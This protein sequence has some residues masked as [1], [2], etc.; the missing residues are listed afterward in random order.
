M[1]PV[2]PPMR[3]FA[4]NPSA[5]SIGV[6]SRICPFH[7]VPSQFQYFTPVGIAMRNDMPA[8]NPLATAPVTN[9]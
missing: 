3:K 5:K 9:M 7:I 6:V 8:K 1:T 4:K 2:I